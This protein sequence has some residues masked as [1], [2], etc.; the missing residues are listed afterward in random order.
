LSDGGRVSG[1]GTPQ[2]QIT[3]VVTNDAG[4]YACVVSNAYGSVTSSPAMFMVTE[5]A[6]ALRLFAEVNGTALRLTWPENPNARLERTT[7]LVSP[8]TWSVVT[9]P[10]AVTGGFK[11]LTLPV[12][13]DAGY[14]RLVRE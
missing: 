13:G 12:L 8:V 7:N 9:N 5:I 1:A 4:S 11:S 2:L 10:P 3:G 6:G 14:F